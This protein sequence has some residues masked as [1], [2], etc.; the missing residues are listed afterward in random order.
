VL[1]A[2]RAAARVVRLTGVSS[3]L[4][5]PE[6]YVLARKAGAGTHP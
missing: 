1:W 5:S 4:Y 6:V 2:C 3:R